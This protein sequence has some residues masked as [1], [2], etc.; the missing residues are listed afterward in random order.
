MSR[1]PRKTSK[2]EAF[3]DDLECVVADALK[4][5]RKLRI[6]GDA[7]KILK[8]KRGLQS[9]WDVGG[10]AITAGSV[11][12]SPIVAGTFFASSAGWLSFIGIGVATT[13]IGWVLAAAV[14]T[15]GAYYGVTRLVQKQTEAMV[16]TIPRFI[17]TPIDLLGMQLLDMVG[18]LALRVASIDGEVAPSERQAI[19]RHFVDEWGYDPHYVS[20]ALDVLT[21]TTDTVSVK[22]IAKM[23]A[24]FQ[25]GN[26]DC[27][28]V[29]MQAELM[30]FL[31]D[32]VAADGRIDEREELAVDAVMTAFK[33]A[34]E[35]TL[36]KIGGGL[37]AL[38]KRFVDALVLKPVV[39]S[40]SKIPKSV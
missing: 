35:L 10:V 3:G 32:V 38:P 36:S 19:E 16:D 7:Y 26:P 24:E 2:P 14:A 17:N 15:G 34:R 29:A 22:A 27:N 18:A 31:R 20:R 13:P 33:A 21:S 12:A 9:I 23:L 25:A 39:L 6:G 5:K 11:A 4:F 8:A 40:T 37:A 30:Q 28:A 1:R